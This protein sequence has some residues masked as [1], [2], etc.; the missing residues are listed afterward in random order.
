MT[1]DMTKLKGIRQM[2]GTG[3][4]NCGAALVAPRCS[5]YLRDIGIRHLWV[6]DGCGYSLVTVASI[7][8]LVEGRNIAGAEVS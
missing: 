5:E 4:A 7:V 1:T 3:C 8:R 2:A 6:C